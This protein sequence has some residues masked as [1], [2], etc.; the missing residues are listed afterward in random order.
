MRRM[1]VNIIVAVLL[2]AIAL[3]IGPEVLHYGKRWI[4]F[5]F[6]DRPNK[7]RIERIDPQFEIS[8]D[9]LIT[10]AKTAGKLWGDVVQKNLFEYD[11]TGSLKINLVYDDRQEILRAINE[12]NEEVAEEK[13][14]IVDT[15]VK[16]ELQQVQLESELE[17][18][19]KTIDYWNSKGGA[20]RDVYNDLVA[21]QNKLRSR[22]ELLNKTAN[23]INSKVTQVNEEIHNL[24][25]QVNNFNSLIKISPEMGLYTS[26]INQIDIFFFGDRDELVHVL[27]HEMGH[28]LG[29][30]HTEDPMSLMNPITSGTTSPSQTDKIAITNLCNNKN[31]IDLIKSDVQNYTYSWVSKLYLMLQNVQ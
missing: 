13:E 17:A 5:S 20:P 14:E 28:S 31:R 24:N 25:E 11:E 3:L 21:R 9:D 27:A 7:Y 2:G 4:S 26:G 18:L 30:Q 10:E 15:S 1:S 12:L 6:C 16:Y 8:K 23:N 22:I 29:L 19:N